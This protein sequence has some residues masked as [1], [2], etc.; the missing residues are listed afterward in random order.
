MAPVS[1]ASLFTKETMTD[2][3]VGHD[4]QPSMAEVQACCGH[5]AILL[6]PF[7]QHAH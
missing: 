6:G 4:G 3:A 1:V 5:G 2:F 7:D